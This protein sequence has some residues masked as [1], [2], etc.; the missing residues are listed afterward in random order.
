MRTT[1]TDMTFAAS[2]DDGSPDLYRSTYGQYD[3]DIAS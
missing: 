3:L 1:G 2:N